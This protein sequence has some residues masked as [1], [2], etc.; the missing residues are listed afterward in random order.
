MQLSFTFESDQDFSLPLQYNHL[1][2]G[3]IY[4]AID[5]E[6]A[7]FLHNRGYLV[8]GRPFRLFV[9]SRLMGPYR[10]DSQAGRIT[11][12]PQVTLWIASPLYEFCTSMIRNIFGRM[13]LHLGPHILRSV[14]SSGD[15]PEISQDRITVRTRSPVTVYSTLYR[16]EGDK[17]TAYFQ[18]G[19]PDYD[20]LV[21]DN[22]KRKYQAA[23]QEEPP[24]GH[25]HVQALGR[26]KLNVVRYK[27]FI[28]KGY[29]GRLRLEGPPPLLQMALNAGL[30]AK[31]SQGFGFIQTS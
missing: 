29:S 6:L 2:Q 10:I 13:N 20:R 11:F 7:D 18:P 26:L 27:G 31:N 1:V 5:P 16:P 15:T 19:E 4:E 23:F 9:F 17:Y 21:T 22:L 12:G 28:I 8:D 14:E 25:V 30:G 24:A 3:F